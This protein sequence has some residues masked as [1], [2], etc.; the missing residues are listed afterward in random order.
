MVEH[1]PDIDQLPIDI[2]GSKGMLEEES[3]LLTYEYHT[4]LQLSR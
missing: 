2:Q 3:C 4:G 1:R